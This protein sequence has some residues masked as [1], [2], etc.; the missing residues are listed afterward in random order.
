VSKAPE[1]FVGIADAAGFL[2]VSVGTLHRWRQ[3]A[4]FTDRRRTRKAPPSYLV[5]GAVKYRLSELEAFAVNSRT[6]A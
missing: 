5:G 1:P 3:N 2:G 6:A 4:G